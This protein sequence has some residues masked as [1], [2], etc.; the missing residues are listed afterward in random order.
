MYVYLIRK[1]IHVIEDVKIDADTRTEYEIE[2]IVT[3]IPH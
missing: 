2:I 1:Q 3:R